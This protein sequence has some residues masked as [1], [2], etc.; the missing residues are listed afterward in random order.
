[1]LSPIAAHASI[2][3]HNQDM[4]CHGVF[5]HAELVRQGLVVVTATC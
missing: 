4:P 2:Q 1:M 5:L 3:K